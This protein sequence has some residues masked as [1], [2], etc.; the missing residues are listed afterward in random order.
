MTVAVALPIVG[1]P[2]RKFAKS[3]ARAGTAGVADNTAAVCRDPSIAS[4]CL[5]YCHETNTT[6]ANTPARIAPR[7]W[8]FVVALSLHGHMRGLAL[9]N[10]V[11]YRAETI[12]YSVSMEKDSSRL[13]LA[14]EDAHVELRDSLAKVR[15][16]DR[17]A[18]KR[19]LL[20]SHRVRNI[21]D[22]LRL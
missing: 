20:L 6:R 17:P 9:L 11:C 12:R 13:R 5:R 22:W 2:K 18:R 4:T 21:R 3:D 10:A 15:L 8:S 7:S 16:A 1:T 14:R 19:D